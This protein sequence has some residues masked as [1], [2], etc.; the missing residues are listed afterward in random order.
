MSVAAVD[1][2]CHWGIHCCGREVSGNRFV[3]GSYASNT[4]C[5]SS[6]SQDVGPRSHDPAMAIRLSRGC[7]SVVERAV[8]GLDA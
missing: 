8:E 4:A 7:R 5:D 6:G 3:D 1:C 2:E